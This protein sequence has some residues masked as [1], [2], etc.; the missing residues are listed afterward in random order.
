MCCGTAQLKPCRCW[1]RESVTERRTNG[2]SLGQLHVSCWVLSGYVRAQA[3]FR[4]LSPDFTPLPLA[5]GL[6]SLALPTKDE[7]RV[8]SPTH[9][10]PFPALPCPLPQF[11]L[12]LGHRHFLKPSLLSRRYEKLSFLVPQLKVNP[13]VV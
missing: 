9:C 5:L 1:M 6:L 10:A 4:P 2:I 12:S 11:W 8:R 3:L 13:A 7:L